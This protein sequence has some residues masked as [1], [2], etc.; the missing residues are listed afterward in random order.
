MDSSIQAQPQAQPLTSRSTNTHL[1]QQST[2]QSDAKKQVDIDAN[3][4]TTADLLSMD[5][6]RKALQDKL[7]NGVADDQY[8]LSLWEAR[9]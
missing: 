7:Q 6:H 9:R 4:S 5:Y 1:S 8:V 2:M 3:P